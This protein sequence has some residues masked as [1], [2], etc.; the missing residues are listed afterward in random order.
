MKT[1]IH[2]FQQIEESLHKVNLDIEEAH[3]LKSFGLFT[4][5]VLTIFL[6]SQVG[7]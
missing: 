7:R 3:K 4:V 6:L 2:S 1:I 5:L